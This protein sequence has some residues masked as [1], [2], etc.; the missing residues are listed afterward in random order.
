M[1]GTLH[2]V[3]ATLYNVTAHCTTYI[4]CTVQDTPH[5]VY[6]TQVQTSVLGVGPEQGA[7]QAGEVSD[8]RKSDL[9]KPPD[10]GKDDISQVGENS[11]C[12][13]YIRKGK[14][15]PATSTPTPTPPPGFRN[16]LD[17]RALVK[18]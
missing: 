17:W 14:Y 1:Q 15:R 3:Y 8:Y 13:S 18:D 2:T 11:Y 12:E 10:E 9:K 5:T 4:H 7:V 6:C 16:W